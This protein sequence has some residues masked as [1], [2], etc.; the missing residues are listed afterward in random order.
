MIQHPAV[1]ALTGGALLTSMQML[2]AG[3]QGAKILRQWDLASG[4]EQQVQLERRTYLI[5]TMVGYALLFQILSLFL[6]IFTADRL[7]GLFIGAMCAA[8]TL[9]VNGFGY[10]TLLLKI[11]NSL[12]AGIWLVVNHLDTKGYDYP[13]IRVKYGLLLLLVPL[14]LLEGGLQTA[15]FLQLQPDVITSCCGSLF[16]AGKQSLTGDL[17]ALPPRPMQWLFFGIMALLM[18][19]GGRFWLT[20]KGALLFAGTSVITLV[21]AVLSLLSFISLYIY[22]LPTHHCPFCIFQR[23]YGFIGYPL[24]A[25]LIIGGIAGASVGVLQRFRNRPSLTRIIPR[26]QRR[27]AGCTML[28]YLLFAAIAVYQMTA[29]HFCLS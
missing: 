11:G 18:L 19:V 7:H 28:V 25:A 5:A 3:W 6:F 13:L 15:Y 2:A 12:L 23:E 17:S 20:G 8:G 14:V 1:I 16:G 22:E 29:T 24:Y 27:L 4:S 21:V 9:H 26:S 10:P